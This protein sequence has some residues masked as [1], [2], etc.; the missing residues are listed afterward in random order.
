MSIHENFAFVN[1]FCK[2]SENLPEK[3]QKNIDENSPCVASGARGVRY[4][5]LYG[6][7]NHCELRIAN[8]IFSSAGQSL[9]AFGPSAV[10]LE[11]RTTSVTWRKPSKAE[12]PILV[13]PFE[14][15]ILVALSA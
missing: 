2:N 9:K 15:T 1:E 8:Y 13:M 4:T 14:I 5:M 7:K 3:A 10:T 6:T 11:G 12:A